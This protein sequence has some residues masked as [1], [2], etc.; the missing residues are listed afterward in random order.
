[1]NPLVSII[2][3]VYNVEQYLDQCLQSVIKQTYK[4]LEILVID[5]DSPD[6]SGA[7]ADRYSEIDSRVKIIHIQNRGAA[8]ARNIG[9][10]NCTGDYILFVDSDDW[11]EPVFVET[12]LKSLLTNRCEF[13]QCQY[14]NEYTDKTIIH[15]VNRSGIYSSSEFAEDMLTNWEDILLWNKMFSASVLDGIRL[16]EGHCIDDEF[17]T[18]KVVI[19]SERIVII[20]DCL[21]HYRNRKS[22]AMMNTEKQHQRLRDQIDFV[23]KRYDPLCT[24]Y[25][26]IQNKVLQHLLEVLM[27]VMRTGCEYPDIFNC[28]KSELQKYGKSAL[29][30]HN[31]DRNIRKSVLLYLVSSPI[32]FAEMIG[33]KTDLDNY[34]E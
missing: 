22:S 2:I 29:L 24:A 10:D 15:T 26:L 3:P 21:Y 6:N 20:D 16:E 14:Y 7:I 23:T 19:R 34:F 4:N 32:K 8:G 13:V 5:D 11:L 30:N 12:M 25:P 9:L 17:F 31:I 1:M 28:A 18:Y 27:T 33:Q